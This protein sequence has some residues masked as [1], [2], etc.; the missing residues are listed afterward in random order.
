MRLMI[1]KPKRLKQILNPKHAGLLIIDLQEDFLSDIGKTADVSLKG[2]H[3]MQKIIPTINFLH[4]IFRDGRLP[5]IW[6][7]TFEDPKYRSV[8]DIDRFVW[9]EGGLESHVM[10]LEHTHGADLIEELGEGDELLKK[11]HPSAYRNTN[12]S[13]LIKKHSI[14]TLYVVGVKTNRCVLRTIQDLHENEEDLHVVPIEDAIATDDLEQQKATIKELKQFY[15]PVI[16][17]KQL[18]R[19]WSK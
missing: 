19:A 10:C 6:T 16:T 13:N 18:A 4:D 8:A 14:K 17:S 9:L 5:T 11:Y 3:R 7:Q 12:L 2:L 15:P 1:S